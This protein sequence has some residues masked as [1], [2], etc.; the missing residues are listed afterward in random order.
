VCE[1][2]CGLILFLGSSV[3]LLVGMHR[4]LSR[5]GREMC[6]GSSSVACVCVWAIRRTAT[7]QPSD[8]HPE[9]HICPSQSTAIES[10][11][12]PAGTHSSE[13]QAAT[14]LALPPHPHKTQGPRRIDRII[15]KR[16]AHPS[17]SP[18][19]Q[20]SASSASSSSRAA[21]LG[22]MAGAASALLIARIAKVRLSVKQ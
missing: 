16:Q 1:C 14:H 22:F 10:A 11:L 7:E 9:P 15:I 13:Q 6:L 12:Q 17:P 20:P 5:F 18:S 3:H 4:L 8:H 2:V 19:M 21:A